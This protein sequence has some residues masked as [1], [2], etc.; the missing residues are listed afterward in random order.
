MPQNSIMLLND[1]I[2]KFFVIPKVKPTILTSNFSPLDVKKSC[3][4][5]IVKYNINNKYSYVYCYTYSIKIHY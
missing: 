1:Y 5:I 2:R 3:L 4:C